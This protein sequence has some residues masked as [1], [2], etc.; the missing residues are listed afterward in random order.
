MS[1]LTT[2]FTVS[3]ESSVIESNFAKRL[4]RVRQKSGHTLPR[5]RTRK[6]FPE[7]CRTS[8]VSSLR[9][10]SPIGCCDLEPWWGVVRRPRAVAVAA[11]DS[12]PEPEVE[13]AAWHV[14]S[15]MR[16]GC[17]EASLS[18]GSRSLSPASQRTVAASDEELRIRRAPCDWSTTCN[19]CT[20]YTW[21]QNLNGSQHGPYS[22]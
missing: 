15:E 12:G 6:K 16:R 18:L 8:S 22:S 19:T 1:S 3:A 20:A 7:N 14:G 9:R 17:V 13:A 2:D 10:C 11:A 5:A 21:G 4:Y